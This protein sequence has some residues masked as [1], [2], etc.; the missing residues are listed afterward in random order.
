[1]LG[2]AAM[3]GV[4]FALV[5]IIAQ[6]GH[7]DEQQYAL[8]AALMDWLGQLG[9]P[10]LGLRPRLPIRLRWLKPTSNAAN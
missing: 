5:Q 6:R 10:A 4:L 9:I 7:Q 1:M 2:T 3:G 8:F